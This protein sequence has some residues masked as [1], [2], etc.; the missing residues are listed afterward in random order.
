MN[1]A[2]IRCGVAAIREVGNLVIRAIIKEIGE[3]RDVDCRVG[4]A[5]N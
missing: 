5:Q 3:N 2:V 4:A 1:K